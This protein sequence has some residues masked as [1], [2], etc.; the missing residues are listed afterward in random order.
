MTR[1]PETVKV[2]CPACGNYYKDCYGGRS[3]EAVEEWEDAYLEICF[4]YTCPEC[5][6]EVYFFEQLRVSEDGKT[7]TVTASWSR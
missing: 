5:G 2:E 6:Y 4:S 1:Q 3:N 7:W